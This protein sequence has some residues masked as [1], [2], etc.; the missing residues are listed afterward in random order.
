MVDTREPR[1]PEHIHRQI[2]RIFIL[3]SEENNGNGISVCVTY[4]F[5]DRH[6][7][8]PENVPNS[9]TSPPASCVVVD[10]IEESENLGPADFMVVLDIIKKRDTQ[11]IVR[12]HKH[13]YIPQI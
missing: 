4:R 13:S 2:R 7:C 8:F 3:D 5:G 12:S 6:I 10:D 9:E 1:K 11:A